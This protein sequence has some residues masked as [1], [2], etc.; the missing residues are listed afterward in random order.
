MFFFLISLHKN[1]KITK[2]FYA[3]EFYVDTDGVALLEIEVQVRV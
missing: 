2:Q 1:K 3:E